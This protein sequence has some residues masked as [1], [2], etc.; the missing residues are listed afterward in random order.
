MMWKTLLR[1]VSK[2]LGGI[3]RTLT[4]L[5][6]L[7]CLARCADGQAKPLSKEELANAVKKCKT[8][9]TYQ[10]K[11]ELP[12]NWLGK[13]EKYVNEPVLKFRIAQD[14]TVYGVKLVRRTGAKKLDAYIV[15][16]VSAWKYKPMP[17]CEVIETTASITIDFE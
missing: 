10:P 7:G 17:A 15:R 12:E 1:L 11:L 16:Y 2:N 13:D 6:L 9:L 5:I 8:N 14:G 3:V 4:T